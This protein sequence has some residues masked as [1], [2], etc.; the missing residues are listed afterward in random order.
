MNSLHAIKKAFR[1]DV[2]NRFPL[3][4]C[5][6]KANSTS[7]T[8]YAECTQSRGFNRVV[9]L[10]IS[11]DLHE[12]G[13]IYTIS[14]AGFGRRARQSNKG[15]G[16]SLELAIAALLRS[17]SPEELRALTFYNTLETAPVSS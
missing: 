5:T 8:L 15:E 12:K 17:V 1:T 13:D 10:R 11:K 7:S 9:T 14:Y 3:C 4:K 6:V 16:S 2:V